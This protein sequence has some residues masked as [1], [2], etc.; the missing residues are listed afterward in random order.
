MYPFT[1]RLHTRSVMMY[2]NPRN[3]WQ[4]MIHEPCQICYRLCFGAAELAKLMGYYSPK[5]CTTVQKCVMTSLF[6]MVVVSSWG[7]A[8]SCV[9]FMLLVFCSFVFMLLLCCCVIMYC[10]GVQLLFYVHVILL[11]LDCC[12]VLLL[13]DW[14]NVWTLWKSY[15]YKRWKRINGFWIILFNN[16]TKKYKLVFA[17]TAIELYSSI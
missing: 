4:H 2:I 17:P 3:Q 16:D 15:S 9:A 5:R 11:A 8:C 10:Y 13:R 12:G 14:S 1:Q 7:M 6:F